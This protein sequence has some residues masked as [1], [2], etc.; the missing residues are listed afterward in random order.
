MAG[1]VNPKG[2][3]ISYLTDHPDLAAPLIPG[4]LEHWRYIL[5][6][7]TVET[8]AAHVWSWPGI[9]VPFNNWLRSARGPQY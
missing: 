8:R 2:M 5:P 1:G 6:E 3:R 4:L 7:E 9:W